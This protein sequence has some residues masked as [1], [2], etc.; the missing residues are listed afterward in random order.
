MDITGCITWATGVN[1]TILESSSILVGENATIQEETLSGKKITI[2][3][4]SFVPKK[5]SIEMDFDWE[6]P[7]RGSKTEYQL[8]LEWYEYRHK[9]GTVPF[10]FPKIIYSPRTG[11]KIEDENSPCEYEYYKIEG[12]IDGVKHGSSVKVKMTWKEVYSGILSVADPV[13][14]M[15]GILK[16]TKN[17]VEVSF[18]TESDVEPFQSDFSLIIDNATADIGGF[19]FDSFEGRLYFVSPLLS[20]KHRVHVQYKEDS[21]IW[22]GAV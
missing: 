15:N 4:G 7:I 6:K 13:S 11:I 8:F 16:V 5:Y 14:M 2:L 20:G 22:E 18:S 12:S 3:K 1:K 17:Y 9:F 10:I 21:F 19:A